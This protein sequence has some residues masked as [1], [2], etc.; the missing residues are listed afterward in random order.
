MPFQFKIKALFKTLITFS[1]TV[2]LKL[3]ILD[4]PKLSGKGT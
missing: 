4:I 3:K 2:I 1:L